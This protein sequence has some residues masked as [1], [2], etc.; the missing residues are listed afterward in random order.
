MNRRHAVAPFALALV[1]AQG[2][3]LSQDSLPPPPA[4]AEEAE[5]LSRAQAQPEAETSRDQAAIDI[6]RNA[7]AAL[8]ETKTVQAAVSSEIQADSGPLAAFKLGADGNVL[9][10]KNDDGTWTRLLVGS[11]DQIGG[12]QQMPFTVLKT[13]EGASW[14]DTENKELVHATGRYAKGPVYSS[15]ELLGLHYL[16]GTSDPYAKE[17]S[18]RVL[19]RMGTEVVGGT[20]CDVIRVEYNGPSLP[21]RWYISSA[22]GFP[23]KIVEELME[24]AIRTYDFTDVAIN[25][26]IDDTRFELEAPDGYAV[27]NL[28]TRATANNTNNPSMTSQETS[29]PAIRPF[30]PE[31][32]KKAPPFAAQNIFGEEVTLA[33]YEG[34]PVVLYFWASWVPGASDIVDELVDLQDHVEGKANLVTFALRE[35][36]PEAAVNLLL[37]ED[38]DDVV[39]L[40]HGPR[41]STAYNVARMPVVLVLDKDHTI[42]FRDEEYKPDETVKNAKAKLAEVTGE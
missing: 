34:E 35:R 39:I 3:A 18:A 40:T 7:Q 28:P 26:S 41:V 38:R 24:G 13:D 10:K 14:I 1:L 22:D 31:E 19:E 6:L 9:I 33:D 36:Q 32:G 17:L 27:K 2:S 15:A 8:S 23:R 30:A 21:L 11:A 25:E 4:D 37:E 16:L 42:V 29:D 5:A 12:S 20:V